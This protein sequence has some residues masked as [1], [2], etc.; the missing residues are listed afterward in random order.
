LIQIFGKRV[1]GGQIV[2]NVNQEG[3]D[4]EERE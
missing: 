4:K 2:E 3:S 1:D